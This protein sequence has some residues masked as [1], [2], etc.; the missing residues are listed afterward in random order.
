MG[1]PTIGGD[2]T[3]AVT[4]D[5]GLLVTGDLDDV[6]WRTGNNDDTWSI[7]V[8]ASYGT[9][10]ID[11]DTG[12]WSYDLDE[13]HPAVNALDDG[14]TLNDV[15]TVYMVDDNG[16]SDTQVVTITITGVPCFTAGT[17][18]ETRD[19]PRPVEDIRAG[20][21]VRT[22]DQGLQMVRWAGGRRL[23]PADLVLA[24]KMRPVRIRAGALGCGLPVRDLVVSPQ[25]RV[26]VQSR[27]AERVFGARQVLVAAVKLLDLPGI[28][29]V[30]SFA[31]VSYHH[32]L[33]DDH[34][35]VI[36]N[37]APSESLYCGPEALK[38]LGD[39][40][41]AEI[42]HLFPELID[43]TE[44]PQPA[45]PFPA[46]GKDVRRFVERALKNG[47]AALQGFSPGS[48]DA[49]LHQV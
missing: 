32:I 3:G 43:A 25:H 11:P 12:A 21:L 49:G 29:R 44:H 22:L 36:A 27:L 28:D 31:E 2:T 13:D 37:G 18:I 10:T 33:F 14:E 20:D 42:A 26:L 35:V 1:T 16:G 9:A 5:S 23:G 6:G 46:S 8:S 39:E 41:V 15:F 34:Q 19:G 47:R 4:D 24:P 40:A 30:D 38:A 45:R 48:S 17:L 7:S